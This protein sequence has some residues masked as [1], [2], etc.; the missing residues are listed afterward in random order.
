MI[1][2]IS[3]SLDELSVVV[4]M[5]HRHLPPHALIF[6]VGDLASGKTTL[7]SAVA[8]SQGIASGATSPTFS[9]QQC[10]G[11]RL[12]HYDLYRVGTQTFLEMGLHEEF[13]KEGWHLIEW[14]DK[15]LRDFLKNAGYNTATV[16]ITPDGSERRYKIE[17]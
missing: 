10:Y 17:V 15:P 16:T 4:Q 13:D 11:E 6:L 2:E 1:I 14:A 8:K 5:L 7:S 3:A 9:L 12:F